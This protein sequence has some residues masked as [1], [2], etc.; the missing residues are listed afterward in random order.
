M[1]LSWNDELKNS[2]DALS[3]FVV[4]KSDFFFFFLTFEI[5]SVH[6]GFFPTTYKQP[7]FSLIIKQSL[8]DFCTFLAI[9]SLYSSPL[10]PWKKYP[11]CIVWTLY[12][13]SYS[14]SQWSPVFHKATVSEVSGGLVR[15]KVKD[16]LQFD[17]IFSLNG[18][19]LGDCVRWW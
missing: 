3:V 18:I 2:V 17:F 9:P 11:S 13:S 16:F 10:S 5:L 1:S 15:D 19:N 14:P 7:K 12:S 4:Q 8:L 6:S